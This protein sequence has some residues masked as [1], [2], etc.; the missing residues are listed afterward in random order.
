MIAIIN[1]LNWFQS[2]EFQSL[3][4]NCTES[5]YSTRK[6]FWESVV[7]FSKEGDYGS[8]CI[9]LKDKV[10]KHYLC[11]RL[12]LFSMFTSNTNVLYFAFLQFMKKSFCL[13]L[14]VQFHWLHLGRWVPMQHWTGHGSVL[15]L[16]PYP[17]WGLNRNHIWSPNLPNSLVL[18]I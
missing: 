5:Y 14:S 4:G 11:R 9:D 15:D 7:P 13:D 18:R 6:F 12:T 17:I 2:T 10:I 16:D 1:L 8:V 3:C